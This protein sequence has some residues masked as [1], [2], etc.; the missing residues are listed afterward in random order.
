[1]V[2]NDPLAMNLSSELLSPIAGNKASPKRESFPD[3]T[4]KQSIYPLDRSRNT[5]RTSGNI[6][7]NSNDS[8]TKSDSNQQF[9]P[10]MHKLYLTNPLKRLP[11]EAFDVIV[12]SLVLSYLP[13]QRQRWDCCIKSNKLLRDNGLLILI[14]SDSAHQHRN[15]HQIRAWKHALT[16]IGFV[17][18][19]YEKLMH[20]HCMAFRKKTNV[21]LLIKEG[22]FVDNSSMMFIPQDFHDEDEEVKQTTFAKRTDEEDEEVCCLFN[23]LP[24][25]I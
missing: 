1:M 18:Y 5:M 12:F 9:I 23:A 22:R 16:G 4:T 7:F 15:A 11:P 17:R 3:E 20:L 2:G 14:E 8:V 13:T 19:R 24:D 10:N 21:D 6:H 25:A